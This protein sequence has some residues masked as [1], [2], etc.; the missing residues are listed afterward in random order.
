[1][2]GTNRG[3]NRE[4]LL[5]IWKPAGLTSHDVVA[6][7]RRLLRMKRIGHT[8][9]LDPQVTGVLPLCL[10]R[11][12]RMVEYIQEA[13]KEYEA[14][15]LIGLATDTEDMEGTIIEQADTVQVTREQVI[16][17][18]VRFEGNIQQIPPMYSALKVDGK[19]LYEWARQGVELERKAREVFI[20]SLTLTDW[21]IRNDGVPELSFRVVCSKGTYIRT[22]CKDIGAALGY[23]SVMNRLV[24]TSTGHI[25]EQRCITLEQ[26]EK[27]VQEDRVGE[28]I[29]PI[30]YP[31]RHIPKLTLDSDQAGR[32]LHGQKLRLSSP[33]EDVDAGQDEVLYRAYDSAGR[34]LGMFLW[35]EA[36]KLLKPKKIMA[37]SD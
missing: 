4:G 17:A 20:Y 3:A 11:A 6:K 13:P 24:R 19:R 33:K 36:Q 7:A 16:S 22:L 26:L 30:D 27:L 2:T 23:P 10:G 29:L 5:P 35:D 9:T 34:F 25:R 32:A 37:E 28:A 12:T 14:S 1:M 15:M 21:R 18:L 31:L 8:G